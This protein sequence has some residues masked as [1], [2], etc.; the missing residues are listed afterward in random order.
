MLSGL[1]TLQTGEWGKDVPVYLD[2]RMGGAST[3]R[4]YDVKT[5]GQEIYGKNQLVG[6]AEYA[7]TLSPLRRYDVGPLSA[8]LGLELAAFLDAGTAWS[9]T[10]DLNIDRTRAGGGLG[11][12]LL[13]P[14]A[15]MVRVDVGWSPDG[16]FH[17]HFGGRI[18]P[19]AARN[20]LR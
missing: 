14:G 13:V 17:L 3:I 5:L 16:G 18:K 20:R 7:W 6:T 15:E 2:F 11:L 8:R 9:R 12:R 19:A 1:A 4:G 10:G